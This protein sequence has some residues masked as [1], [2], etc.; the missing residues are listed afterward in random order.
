M[1]HDN[2]QHTIILTLKVGEHF[3]DLDAIVR[4]E[5]FSSMKLKRIK[6]RQ[7]SVVS[8]LCNNLHYTT[9]NI[10]HGRIFDRT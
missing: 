8:Q 5:L 1:Q 3:K 2:Y 6:L 7:Q 9:P 10:T 4:A